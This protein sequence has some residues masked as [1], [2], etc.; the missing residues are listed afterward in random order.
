[1]AVMSEL[2]RVSVR[3][4][5]V[6]S[7][8]AASAAP[9][10]SAIGELLAYDGFGN[11]PLADLHG[12]QGGTGWAG[13]WFDVM[14]DVV[15]GVSGSGL[16][17]S[18]L[19]STPGAAVSS[20]SD[21]I[22][23][24]SRYWRS[25]GA[26]PVGTTTVYVSFLMRSEQSWGW[27]GLMFGT[28]PQAMLVGVP[29][30]MGT[31]GLQLS[32]GL[33]ADSN[34]PLVADATYLCVVK[35]KKNTAGGGTTWS[36]YVNPTI[37][38]SEPAFP[39]AQ[40]AGPALP[41]ALNIDNGGDFTTDEIRVGTSWSAVLPTDACPYDLDEDGTIGPSDLALVL[42]GWGTASPDITGDG[43]VNA[44]DVAQLLGAWGG[45]P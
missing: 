6:A 11:G 45:C 27:G 37:G 36:L 24:I 13:G 34:V 2:L 43:T 10:A 22:Y 44:A 35:I 9:S 5:C 26:L 31:F 29:D 23:P 25:F 14:G 1:M 38:G 42:G 4:A 12:S 21:S 15:T 18:G 33:G 30:G 16:A 28:Y 7:I 32:Q 17:Y 40:Y 39:T 8:L 3:A 19:A 20:T 41:T